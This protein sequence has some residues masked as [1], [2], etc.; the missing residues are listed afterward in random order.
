MADQGLDASPT[1]YVEGDADFHFVEEL[2]KKYSV[3]SSWRTEAKTGFASVMKVARDA[4]V[5]RGAPTVGIVVDADFN[6]DCRWGEIAEHFAR[7]EVMNKREI[8]LPNRPCQQG[9]IIDEDAGFPRIG[10][11]VMPNN[12]S[13][14]ELEDFVV[15]MVPAGNV[16]WQK[17]KHYI[18]GIPCHERP[19][20]PEKTDR[21]KLYA[22]LAT[23]KKPPYIGFAISNRELNVQT[24]N[25]QLFV[26][27]LTR[28]FA[29]STPAGT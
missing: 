4:V 14:G 12:S 27:W 11:W 9:T 16:I 24:P 18:N 19:F 3:S 20:D 7:P 1:L 2:R 15:Q 29:Q 17:T 6:L 8:S 22:W 25:C 26:D 10:I 5:K 13:T 21:A 28:L 23:C